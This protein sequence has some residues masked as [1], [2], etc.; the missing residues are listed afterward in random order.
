M[1]HDVWH[2]MLYRSS[3]R[4]VVCTHIHTYTHT[5]TYRSSGRC[6]VCDV[7]VV[8]VDAGGEGVH[9]VEDLGVVGAHCELQGIAA[10]VQV[11]LYRYRI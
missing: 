10:E 1:T 11:A 7:S 9:Q 2:M 4:C 3:G 6:I 8:C 5:H